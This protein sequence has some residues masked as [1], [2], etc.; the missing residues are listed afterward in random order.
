L[1]QAELTKSIIGAIG[2]MD[3]YQLPDAKGFTSMV[4]YLVG[5]TDERRQQWR[6]QVLST[7]LEDF[8]A[9]GEVLER[10]KEAGLVVVLGSPEA[11]QRANSQKGGWLE[12]RKIL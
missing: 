12:V 7:T 8:Q 3:A 4:R 10:V 1:S 11:I 2:D 5:D 9:L 6:D